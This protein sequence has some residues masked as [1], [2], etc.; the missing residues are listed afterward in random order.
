[1]KKAIITLFLL[2]LLL[3]TAVASEIKVIPLFIGKVKFTVEVADTME[4]QML[5]L[6]YR[7]SIPDDFGMLFIYPSE[8]H[9]SMWMKNC[10]VH[11]DIIFMDANKQVINIHFNVPPCTGDPC[12]SYASERPAQFA[13]EL[14]ANRAKEL[15]LNPGDHIFFSL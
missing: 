4:K 1:M 7:E 3:F 6:M 12:A 14:R 5:G 11:L 10:R 2:L 15:G 9:R 8:G 13:L